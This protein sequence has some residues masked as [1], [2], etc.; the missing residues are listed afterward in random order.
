[1]G[2]FLYNR[3]IGTEVIRI[4]EV[5]IDVFLAQNVLMDMQLLLLTLLLLKEKINFL[6]LLAASV[7]GGI[8]AVIILMSGVGFNII[9][10]LLVLVLD[11]VMLLI[12]IQ[13][14]VRRGGVF[15]RLAMGIIYL[16]GMVFAYGKLMEC[17]GRLVGNGL[18]QIVV[19]ALI[20]GIVIFMLVYRSLVESK[21]I[22]EVT[23]TEEGE[24]VVYRAL[25]DTGNFL[26]DPVSGKPVSVVE[27]TDTTKG[28][29]KK[30][31]QKYKIIPYQSVGKE[32]GVL[33]GIVVD[34]L[35]IQKE[36]EQV[37]K[38]G[39]VVALYKGKLSKNGDFQMILNH[40]LIM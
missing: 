30:Y 9:Y 1:M 36:R 25:F 2:H 7:S 24:N 4:Y 34:E 5:Y 29:L 20:A 10:I 38:K 15:R 8:G 18:A 37:V 22:Y 40:S 14:P 23:L 19:I 12:C 39:A 11:A 27:E 32:H 6:R 21:H 3:F 28:W 35:I 16:H 26:T 33:E 31:P 17:A 13:Q